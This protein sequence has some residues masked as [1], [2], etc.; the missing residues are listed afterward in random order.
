MK[1][2]ATALLLTLAA[3][4]SPPRAAETPEA[5][6]PPASSFNPNPGASLPPPDPNDHRRLLIAFGDSLTA[7]YGVEPGRSYPDYLQELIDAG[8]KPWRVLNAGISGETTTGGLNRLQAI[9]DQKPAA[10]ILEL[11]GNDGLRG[12]PLASTRDNMQKM[13]TALKGSGAKVILAGM[14]L[15]PNYGPEYI[16]E[17]EGIYR[18]LARREK[19]TLIPFLLEGVATQ[20]GLMQNDGIHPTGDGQKI[21]A[22]TVYRAIKPL[23]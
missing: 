11:G 7:G 12:L 13:V 1:L 10:V 6:K 9:L 5:K 15:P 20:P 8:H 18:D 19:L 22:G 2:F 23:L 17:F 14:T 3:C 16:R 4:S 21:V